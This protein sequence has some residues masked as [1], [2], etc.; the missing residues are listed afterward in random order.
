MEKVIELN[1][2]EEFDDNMISEKDKVF[3]KGILKN[4][5]KDSS[6][7]AYYCT[8]RMISN[9][10]IDAKRILFKVFNNDIILEFVSKEEMEYLRDIYKY[11]IQKEQRKEEMKLKEAEAWK[12]NPE[13]F[14]EKK[15]F[16]PT[17][18]EKEVEAE[19]DI[20][21]VN[22]I[23]FHI[24][25]GQYWK[26]VHGNVIQH[27][28]KQKLGD[29]AMTNYIKN[30]TELI[31]KE[32]QMDG[33]KINHNRNRIILLNGTLDLSDW[34]NPIFYDNKFYRDD[35]GTIQLNCNY[36]KHAKS[37]TFDKYL[38]T[39]FERDD[40]RI[41]LIGEML[42]YCLVP[43]NKFEKGFMLY[44]SGS[45]GKSVLL[46]I[47]NNLITEENISN[48]DLSDLEKSFSRSMLYNK[49]VNLTDEMEGK[50]K[51]S[52]FYKRIASGNTIEA[53][54]KFKD[55]FNFKPFCTMVFAMNNFPQIND[56]T[57]G[58]YRKMILIPFDVTIKE[59]DQD[60][61]LSEK[62]RNELDGI[63][64]IALTG[65]KRLS[66]Q[67]RFTYSSKGNCIMEEFKRNSNPVQIFLMIWLQKIKME[68]LIRK[69]Y[70]HFTLNFAVMKV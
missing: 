24:Y 63:L 48:V 32:K 17:L 29:K 28:I 22:D 51:D 67:N 16:I 49:L 6:E 35:Y 14:F 23:G 30:V 43:S 40:E 33:S 12:Q 60:K 10:Y 61:D 59:E 2:N 1:H 46:Q 50:I 66:E 42:G 58:L 65:L 15:K 52:G 37:P 18:L 31:E 57:H 13:R 38:E 9:D 44:G 54:F 39:V 4:D 5:F 21:F 47:I 68:K 7:V 26:K 70:M 64:Q 41:N 36:N 53:Q 19:N 20:I 62:L 25:N 3:I 11:I 27:I 69:N 34:K 8:E 55:S 45:N 56:K